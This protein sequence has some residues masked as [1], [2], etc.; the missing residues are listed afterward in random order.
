MAAFFSLLHKLPGSSRTF[1]YSV[2]SVAVCA[3]YCQSSKSRSS[4]QQQV[5]FAAFGPVLQLEFLFGL[6]SRTASICW[7]WSESDVL[8]FIVVC[9]RAPGETSAWFRQL[10]QCS[11]CCKPRGNVLASYVLQLGSAFR[12]S[13]WCC[14]WAAAKIW[15]VSSSCLPFFV[16]GDETYQDIFRDFSHMASNNPEKL[17]R[18]SADIRFWATAVCM[19]RADACTRAGESTSTFSPGYMPHVGS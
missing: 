13:L 7:C 8:C 5:L 12:L 17:K 10:V 11:N 18:R 3:I 4:S 2:N 6:Q 19:C 9:C 15:T 14:S 1:L 16:P